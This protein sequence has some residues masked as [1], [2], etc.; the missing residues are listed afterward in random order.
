MLGA[1]ILLLSLLVRY[2][3]NTNNCSRPTE[4]KFVI[5]SKDN[6]LAELVPPDHNIC[7]F[8]FF[9]ISILK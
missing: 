6:I 8:P 3:S 1:K 7:N 5:P 9:D 2:F 4:I